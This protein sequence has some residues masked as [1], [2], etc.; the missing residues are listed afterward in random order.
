M[1][2]HAQHRGDRRQNVDAGDVPLD[3]ASLVLTGKLDEER[4]EGDVADVRPRRVAP[5]VSTA[6][7][8]PLVHGDDDQGL[9][10]QPGPVEAIEK[11]ADQLVREAGLQQV[12]LPA[13]SASPSFHQVSSVRPGARGTATARTRP[14]GK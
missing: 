13:C 6:E 7:A 14:S 2:S 10:P 3:H 12:S 4:D 5:A 8:V 1:H 11:P 9:V